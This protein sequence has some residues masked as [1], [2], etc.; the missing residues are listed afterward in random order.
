MKVLVTGG[1]GYIGSVATKV[2]L[3]A[4]H[5]V[6]VYDS[7]ALGHAAAVSSP[8]RL[9]KGDLAETGA[10]NAAFAQEKPD[11]VM[12]FAAR[13]LVGES[14]EK[15]GQ[16]FHNNVACGV[17][18]LNACLRFGVKR[19][20]FSS[21]AAVYGTPDKVP[22]T[23]DAP[24]AP[25]NPYGG[26]KRVF[27]ALLEEYEKAGGPRYA[28]LRYFNVAGA[29]A[30]LGE[31]HRPETH[32]IPRIL[33]AAADPGFCFELFGDSYDTK[34]GTCVRDY[35]HVHDL[36]RAHLLAMD[37]I[38]ERSWVFN[39]GSE[40]GYTNR[41]VLDAAERVTGRKITCRVAACRAGDPPALVASSARIKRELGWSAEKPLE[42]MIADAWAFLQQF[43]SG[44]P[45]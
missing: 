14:V 31:D 37:A 42:A 32:L 33:R 39:L 29:Y 1:A 28:S 30:G 20:V 25:I 26:T 44:Y 22:I 19:F 40:S 38:A 23:E 21:S 16:Y 18:L 34:D 45:D 10:L 13:S 17:S 7:L 3:E 4:G 11:C 8:A 41:E 27:E 36:A 5:D 2:L 6:A 12:H 35:I 15:P 24:L 9:H 43:P